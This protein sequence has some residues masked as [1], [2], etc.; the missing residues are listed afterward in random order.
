[1]LLNML[2][3]PRQAPVTKDHSA[4]NVIMLRL[5]EPGASLYVLICIYFFDSYTLP[6]GL[7]P[8]IQNKQKCFKNRFTSFRN[9]I[10][11]LSMKANAL[12]LMFSC[13]SVFWVGLKTCGIIEGA[14]RKKEQNKV[15][16]LYSKDIEN[17]YYKIHLK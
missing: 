16:S 7:D 3:Y 4:Q 10:P 5:R 12:F 14:C 9:T 6:V 11:K 15:S 8:F 13:L 17:N 2:Q 1:M